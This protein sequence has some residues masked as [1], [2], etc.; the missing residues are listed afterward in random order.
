[1]KDTGR[2]VALR[3]LDHQR[4][5]QAVRTHP[6]RDALLAPAITRRLV[7]QFISESTPGATA[8]RPSQPAYPA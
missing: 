1:M 8:P 5:A 4:Q 7:E 2:K 6:E 3:G